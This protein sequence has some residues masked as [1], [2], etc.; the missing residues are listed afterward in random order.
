MT[1]LIAAYTTIWRERR[2]ECIGIPLV[3]FGALLLAYVAAVI[4]G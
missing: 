3:F 4:G 1:D 2:S